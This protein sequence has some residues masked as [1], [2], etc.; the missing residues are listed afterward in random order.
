MVCLGNI[1]RS[2]TAEAAVREA[3]REE[4]V[5]LQVSSA[6]TGGWHVGAPPDERMRAAASDVGLTLEGAAAQVT[7]EDIAAADL[8]LAM[9]RTNYQDLLTLAPEH[10][11]RIRMFREFEDAA[12][13]PEEAPGVPDPYYGGPDGFAEAVRIVRRAARGLVRAIRDGEV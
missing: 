2:P 4:G 9:D 3:A 10:T 12:W 1:C 5:E 8:V 13:G 11:A 7:S 6:G